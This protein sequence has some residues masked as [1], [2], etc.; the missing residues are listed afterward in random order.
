V[1]VRLCLRSIVPV[2]Q[3]TRQ[4]VF[5]T[6]ATQPSR[7]FSISVRGGLKEDPE[8]SQR[9]FSVFFQEKDRPGLE[10]EMEGRK[11]LHVDMHSRSRCLAPVTRSGR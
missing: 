8:V 11:F 3:H 2:K 10:E 9:I 1:D 4:V 6:K 7:R 5:D